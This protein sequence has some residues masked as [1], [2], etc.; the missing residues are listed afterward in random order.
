MEY[1]IVALV[2]GYIGWRASSALNNSLHGEMLQELGVTEQQLRDLARRKGLELDDDGEPEEE[3]S[4]VRIAV[5]IEQHQGVLY[6]FN[7]E[8]DRFLA[9]G[10]DREEL[11]TRIRDQIRGDAD[12]RLIITSE[13][14]AEFVT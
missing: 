10:A 3:P 5:R 6:C 13:D 7:K 8:D 9:Q 11:L 12:I 14:G 2:A 4:E 1:L